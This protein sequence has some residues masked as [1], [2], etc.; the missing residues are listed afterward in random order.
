MTPSISQAGGGGQFEHCTITA[1]T[2][3]MAAQH[4]TDGDNAILKKQ[5]Q[6]HYRYFIFTPR[7]C[8]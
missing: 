3:R 6:Q 7:F 5:Q 1:T 8:S 2:M 4:D